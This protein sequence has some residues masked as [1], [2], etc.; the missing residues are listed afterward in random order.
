MLKW[1]T[2]V[3]IVLSTSVVNDLYVYM[4]RIQL[5]EVL[6]LCFFSDSLEDYKS[7][8]FSKM[9]IPLFFLYVSFFYLHLSQK[10]IVPLID[11]YNFINLC[12][13]LN[14]SLLMIF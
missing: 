9:N 3:I 10:V 1:V 7:H 8:H 2:D 11:V 5:Q 14:L 13:N 6:V 12:V 4:Y